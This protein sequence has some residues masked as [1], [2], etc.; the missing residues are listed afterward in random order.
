MRELI[1]LRHA[2]AMSSSPDGSDMARPLNHR[3][4]HEARHAG[5]W[6]S[7]HRAQPDRVLCSPARRTMETSTGVLTSLGP[8]PVRYE[9]DIYEATPGRLIALLDTHADAESVL[10]I[11]HNPGLEQLLALLVEGRSPDYRG[12]APAALAWIE[13]DDGLLEPGRGRLKAFWS[14]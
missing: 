11:G 9:P 12:M 4:E 2:K 8:L 3:G 14:P 10:L 7:K 1:L 6:L 13:L 5:E